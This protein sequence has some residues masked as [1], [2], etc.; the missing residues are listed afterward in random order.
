MPENYRTAFWAIACS[1]P[2][3]C[4]TLGNTPHLLMLQF[5]PV[6]TTSSVVNAVFGVVCSGSLLLKHAHSNKEFI[7]LLDECVS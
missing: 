4:C 6:S 3:T 5:L 1:R 2:L 7:G